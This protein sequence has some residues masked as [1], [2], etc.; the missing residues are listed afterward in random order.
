[1]PT[2][3]TLQVVK[4]EPAI[5][6]DNYPGTI[7]ALSQ[8]DLHAQVSGYITGIFF[9]EGSHVHKGQK[10]YEIDRSK[11]DAAYRQ[12]SA[13]LVQARANQNKAQ[14]DA[15]RYT[16]LSQHDAIAK[17]ILDHA[18]T[19]LENAKALVSSAAAAVASAQ[20][21]LNF[22]TINAPF[23]GTIGLSQVKL[24]TLVSQGQTLLATISTDNPVAV[25]FV[26]NEKEIP[27]FNNLEHLQ[28]SQTDSLFTLRLADGSTYNASGKIS[29]LDRAVDPQTGT[30]RV[31]LVFPNSDAALRAGMSCTVRVHNQGAAEQILIP[32]KATLEQMGEYFVFVAKDT[33]IAANDNADKKSSDQAPAPKGPQLKAIQRKVQL[34][35]VIDSNVIVKSGLEPGER[36]IVNGIQ[37]LRE[38]A[39]VTT[40]IPPKQPAADASK[41]K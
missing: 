18:L 37:K 33:V 7:V 10:L 17:Q 1:M 27:R 4:T 30:I 28:S 5:Y 35:Q 14:K 31:R 21:D 24:G 26:V 38:G 20:T 8:V 22:A 3:V 41:G 6:F 12:A 34:G 40:A 2:P 16:Y 15:D 25:D 39:M 19:D 11:Y 9:K 13:N 32:N 29:V 23:E 36:L